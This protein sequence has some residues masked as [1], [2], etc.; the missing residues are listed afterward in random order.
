L[1]SATKRLEAHPEVGVVCRDRAGVYADD[2][3]TGASQAAWAGRRPLPPVA[4]SGCRFTRNSSEAS[5]G[6]AWPSVELCLS[7]K[8]VEAHVRSIFTKLNLARDA[9]DRR[10]VLAVLRI[11]ALVERVVD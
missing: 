1:T 9:G 2:A 5:V 7:A 4:R 6:G 11:P 10:R 3:S 8:T